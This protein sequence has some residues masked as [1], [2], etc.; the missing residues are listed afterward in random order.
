MFVR[1]HKASGRLQCALVETRRVNGSVRQ[2]HI[3]ALGSIVE[4]PSVAD[5]VTFWRK[6]H[7]RLSK[8][9]NRVGAEDHAKILGAI[10][11]R[12]P[13]VI[14][15]EQQAL[16]LENIEADERVWDSLRE[17]WQDEVTGKRA[18]V[19]KLER[20]IAQAEEQAAQAGEHA[21]N[22]RA[23]IARLRKGEP[24][25][26]GLSRL[27]LKDMAGILT[28]AGASASD[29]RHWQRI[30]RLDEAEFEQFIETAH[31]SAVSDR[32]EKAI[33]RAI[34]RRKVAKGLGEV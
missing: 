31:D 28:A 30:A 33:V 12:V 29:I 13:M 2:E 7:E 9:S 8:L 15:A 10:H 17:G 26:G 18:L 27:T 19:A 24:V 34:L 5:R 23:R 32:R 21:V 20:D 11:A 6:L 14:I 1:F 3:A 16:Q 22:A 25:D 4:P